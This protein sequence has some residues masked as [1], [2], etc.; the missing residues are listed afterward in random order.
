MRIQFS[1]CSN[2]R[3]K[4]FANSSLL[5]P[6]RTPSH[7]FLNSSDKQYVRPH[8]E[9]Y[10]MHQSG[11]LGY[12]GDKDTLKKSR[13]KAV[14]MV[15]G[16][17]GT[18]YLPGNSRVKEKGPGHGTGPHGRSEQ[19]WAIQQLGRTGRSRAGTRQNSGGQGLTVQFARTVPIKYTFAVRS[20]EG[21]NKLPVNVISATSNESFRKRLKGHEE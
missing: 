14:K 1:H 5:N 13:R 2:Q 8:L 16:L 4:A 11:H 6:L 12:M 21:W 3:T 15:T 9:F 20:I 17:K 7:S 10:S 18:T 19:Q